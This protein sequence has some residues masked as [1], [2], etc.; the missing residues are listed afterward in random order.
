VPVRAPGREQH[1]RDDD[2]RHKHR[3]TS[4]TSGP[5]SGT[6]SGTTGGSSGG[7]CSASYTTTNSWSGGFQGEV[8]VTAGSTAVNGWTVHRTLANGQTITQ[9]WN[10]NLTTSGTNATV[11]NADYNG[12]LAA[13]ASA[14]FGFL[15]SGT[16][17]TPTLTLTCTSP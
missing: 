10:G 14:T 3:T 15:A 16:P 4:G 9:V 8:K 7:A 6:S 13:S 5:T 1:G 12:T 11:K 17:N 2:R